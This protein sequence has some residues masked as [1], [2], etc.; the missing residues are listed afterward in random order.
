MLG[1]T[2]YVNQHFRSAAS[3]TGPTS[4]RASQH[5]AE[6]DNFSVYFNLD[7]GGGRI[8]GIYAQGNAAAAAVFRQWLAPLSELGATTVTLAPTFG[9]DH[10]S[11]DAA[12]LPGFQFIQ[13]PLEY[14]SRTHHSTADVYDRIPPEDLKQAAVIMATFVYDAAMA[15]Q[16]MPRK[17][18]Y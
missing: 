1:S 11:F 3:R 17:A 15:E 13:D 6:Y 4:R 5:P 12:G 10:L 7:N 14:E 2:A 16:K 9:T 8:R 18:G